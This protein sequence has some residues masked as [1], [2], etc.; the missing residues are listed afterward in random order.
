MTMIDLIPSPYRLLAGAIFAL[1]V[2]TGSALAGAMVNGWRLERAHLKELA[3]KQQEYD[4]LLDKVR[5]Q[6]Q[7]IAT[8]SAVA[9]NADSLRKEAEKR[10]AVVIKGIDKRSAAVAGSNAKDCD[11][12]LREAWGAW[13]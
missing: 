10:A 12:V 6:N 4:A 13:Q 3:V 1:A 8:L 9:Q 2:I 11:G 7:A 5:E